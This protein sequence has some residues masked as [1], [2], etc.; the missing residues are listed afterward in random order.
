MLPLRIFF[1][2]LDVY[3]IHVLPVSMT[4]FKYIYVQLIN[5]YMAL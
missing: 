5:Y 4:Y 1:L 2:C 3:Y